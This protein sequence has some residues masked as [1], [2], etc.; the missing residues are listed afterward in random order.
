MKSFIKDLIEALRAPEGPVDRRA[1][2]PTPMHISD[3][4]PVE[5]D[6]PE[7]T[8]SNRRQPTSP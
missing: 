2:R 1:H 4:G 8:P 6:F 7:Y 3:I 5:V